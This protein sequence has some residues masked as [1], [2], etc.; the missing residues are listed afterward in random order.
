MIGR[1]WHGWANPENADSYERLL[2]SEVLPGIH[3]IAG[4]RVPTCCGA[5]GRDGS[6]S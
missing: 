1:L 2:R 4:H 3:R 5:S 6:S